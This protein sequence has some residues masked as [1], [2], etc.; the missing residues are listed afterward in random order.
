MFEWNTLSLDKSV[1]AGGR[2]GAYGT[3]RARGGAGWVVPRQS[4]GRPCRLSLMVHL[5]YSVALDGS[6]FVTAMVETPLDLAAPAK[7][8]WPASLWRPRIPRKATP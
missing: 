5:L 6:G 7:A 3:K 8:G 4:R 1:V 2:P